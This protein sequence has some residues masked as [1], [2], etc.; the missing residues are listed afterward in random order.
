M[1]G[2]VLKDVLSAAGVEEMNYLG[3]NLLWGRAGVRKNYD[4]P[5]STEHQA[6]NFGASTDCMKDV[7]V[8]IEKFW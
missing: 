8:L 4:I 1:G 5:E 2:G 7:A 3:K 6:Q